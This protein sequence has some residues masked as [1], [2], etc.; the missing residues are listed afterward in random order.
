METP[1]PNN[2]F[3]VTPEELK[4]P[5]ALINALGSIGHTFPTKVVPITSQEL[6]ALAER[7]KQELKE[8]EE[9]WKVDENPMVVSGGGFNH[10]TAFICSDD[11]VVTMADSILCFEDDVEGRDFCEY[12]NLHGTQPLNELEWY[13]EKAKEMTVA[14][15]EQLRQLQA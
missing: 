13:D 15:R 4:S 2:E 6:I 9:K 1:N 7:S 11:V 12:L 10:V 8:K 3:I 5:Q 14:L